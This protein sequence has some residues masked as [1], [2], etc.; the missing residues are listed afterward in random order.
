MKISREKKK[1]EAIKRM[2]TLKL[3]PGMVQHFK[4]ENLVGMCEP[5]NGAF[6]WLDDDSKKVVEEFEKKHDALV[7]TAIR[8]F[9]EMGILD[10]YLFVSDYKEEWDI[11]NEELNHGET[12]AY[13]YN[14]DHTELSEM[15]TIGFKRTSASGLERIW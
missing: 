10:S 13:V 3:Y 9:T 6:Y 15:G 14:K 12:L 5:P 8:N 11:E 2:K 1:E 4:D 7:Y